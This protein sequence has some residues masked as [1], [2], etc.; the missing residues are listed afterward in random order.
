M[1]SVWLSLLIRSGLILGAAEAVRALLRPS[2]ARNRHAVLLS[3]FAL[4]L[5][6]PFLSAS[7]PEFSLS[8]P[9]RASVTATVTV[10]QTLC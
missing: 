10:Q 7:L 8:I 9:S 4:L 6:W 5:A 2:S 3:A 1:L